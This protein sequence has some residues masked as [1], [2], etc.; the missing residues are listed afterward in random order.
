M[1]APGDGPQVNLPMSAAATGQQCPPPVRQ[2]RRSGSA[3]GGT[4][5]DVVMAMRRCPAR[6]PPST[7]TDRPLRAMVPCPSA[8]A[9]R[10]R[11]RT[12]CPVSLSTCQPAIRS[13]GWPGARRRCWASSSSSWC[14]RV[15]RHPAV[16]CSVVA[17]SAIRLA[18]ATGEPCRPRRQRHHLQRAA[19]PLYLG[20]A[21][22]DQYIP[23][24]TIGEGMGLQHR[25]QLPRRVDVRVGLLPRAGA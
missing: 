13:N 17:T 20:R 11:G 4:V 2:R 23:V 16:P 8:R 25:A 21:K 22:L 15:D 24:S 19:A 5:N 9:R 6:L 12:G 7:L 18:A 10:S 14:R 1:V 3:T